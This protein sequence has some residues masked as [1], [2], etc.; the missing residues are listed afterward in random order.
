MGAPEVVA[1]ETRHSPSA[2]LGLAQQWHVTM[3]LVE[4]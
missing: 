2:S 4:K 3:L 1:E